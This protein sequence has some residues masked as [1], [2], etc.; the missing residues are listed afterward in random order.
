MN[1]LYLFLLGAALFTAEAFTPGFF[2]GAVGLALIFWS[3]LLNFFNNIDNPLLLA[4]EPVLSAVLSMLVFRQIYNFSTQKKISAGVESLMGEEG[5]VVSDVYP[6]R[7][8]VIR[9]AGEDWSAL[10]QEDVIKKKSKVKIVGYGG[11]MLKV[12]ES[13][14]VQIE[15]TESEK[16]GKKMIK[17]KKRGVK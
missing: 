16:S 15:K 9:V 3:A 11:V 14:S 2:I 13:E 4:T 17:R 7:P 12:S 5:Y 10:S 1:P 8:G 6:D